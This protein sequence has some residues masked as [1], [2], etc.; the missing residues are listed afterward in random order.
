M[1]TVRAIVSTTVGAVPESVVAGETGILVPSADSDA[2][3]SPIVDL[4]L[5][6]A[7]RDQM[8]RAG[9]R[10][11]ESA[12]TLDRIFEHTDA[13]YQAYLRESEGR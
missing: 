1:T 11:V 7:K 3:A 6:P 9:P 12:F 10:C 13:L 4:L 5:D 8:A 2:L